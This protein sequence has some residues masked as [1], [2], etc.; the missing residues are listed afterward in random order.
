MSQSTAEVVRAD[1][2]AIIYHVSVAPQNSGTWQYA[3][4]EAMPCI[5]YHAVAIILNIDRSK[6]WESS[7]SLHCFYFPQTSWESSSGL[8]SMA[9]PSALYLSSCK[10]LILN[11]AKCVYRWCGCT[12]RKESCRWSQVGTCTKSYKFQ[13]CV[14]PGHRLLWPTQLSPRVDHCAIVM[15]FAPRFNGP[16][17]VADMLSMVCQRDT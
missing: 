10:H 16:P 11:M 3:R 13:S 17:K 8:D 7:T 15:P 2:Y 9:A 5:L 6:Q 12:T 1:K 4:T 14:I